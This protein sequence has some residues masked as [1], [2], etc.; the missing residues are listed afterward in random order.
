MCRLLVWNKAGSVKSEHDAGDVISVVKNSHKFSPSE[1]KAVWIA[2]GRNPANWDGHTWVI[3]IPD[4]T[5]RRGR[6]LREAHRE[7]AVLGD[8]EFDAPDEADRFKQVRVRKFRMGMS[9][10]KLQALRNVGRV[11]LTLPQARNF[12]QNLANDG[13]VIDFG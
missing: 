1:C 3:D 13:E 6:R 4:M 7:P 8:V 5:V 9:G 10:P 2:R 11:S 12:F